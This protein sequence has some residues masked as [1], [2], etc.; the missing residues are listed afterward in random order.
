MEFRCDKCDKIFYSKESFGGHIGSH[1]RGDS[2][3]N[4]RKKEKIIILK[5]YICKHCGNLF[6][7]GFKL[8]GHQNFCKLNP[9]R[10]NTINKIKFSM[11]GKELKKE[12]KE[13]I[14][15]SRIEYLNKNPDLHPWKNNEK[16][17]SIP[18]EYFKK[19]L[20]RNGF[21]FEEEFSPIPNRFFSTDIALVE[22]KICIE[23]NGEQHY[24]RNGDLKKYYKD[25]HELIEKSGW[26][27]IE[28]HYLK[29]Y[30]DEYV[31]KILERIK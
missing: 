21:I 18:C 8:G 9:L 1:N 4:G 12:S 11:T 29:V 7:N 2:Y 6:E 28:I 15:L 5:N 13:K 24:D 26:T 22:N 10:E 27:V 31:R 3:K 16:F 14:S 23:I 30:D 19:I 20:T 25:R 17:K